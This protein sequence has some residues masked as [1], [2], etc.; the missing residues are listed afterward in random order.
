[1]KVTDLRSI[2]TRHAERV[3]CIKLDSPDTLPPMFLEMFDEGGQNSKRPRKSFDESNLAHLDTI[4]QL[5]DAQY[6]EQNSPNRS[7][8]AA[9]QQQ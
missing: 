3:L 4:P 5:Q 7:N 6:K 2:S 9:L 1:M 8:Q